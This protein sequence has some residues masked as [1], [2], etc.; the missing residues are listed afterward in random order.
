MPKPKLS[1]RQITA[2]WTFATKQTKVPAKGKLTQRALNL[3]WENCTNTG[4]TATGKNIL[5]VSGASLSRIFGNCKHAFK[6]YKDFK[7]GNGQCSAS[8]WISG[9]DNNKTKLTKRSIKLIKIQSKHN[10]QVNGTPS[11]NFSGKTRHG[12]TNTITSC[13]NKNRNN[14]KRC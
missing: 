14:R 2:Q 5:E 1:A 13:C 6:S 12:R 11:I 10:K 3:F 4:N 7:N 9:N 8:L